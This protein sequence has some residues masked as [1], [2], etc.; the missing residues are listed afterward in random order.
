MHAAHGNY[1]FYN[2]E[3]QSIYGLFGGTTQSGRKLQKLK[4]GQENRICFV[5]S[6]KMPQRLLIPSL[7]ASLLQYRS[8]QF[9][10]ALRSQVET[11]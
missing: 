6:K 11:V 10:H 5:V 2:R 9:V 1:L 4:L 3:P 7:M 8:K